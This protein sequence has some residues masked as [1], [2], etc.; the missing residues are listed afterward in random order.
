MR[1]NSA[2]TAFKSEKLQYPGNGLKETY[3][4]TDLGNTW[5]ITLK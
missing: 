2:V 4:D 5:A 1:L 3:F